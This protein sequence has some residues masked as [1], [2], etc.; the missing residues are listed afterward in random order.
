[1]KKLIKFSCIGSTDSTS[2]SRKLE[3]L[4]AV[5]ETVQ[6]SVSSVSSTNMAAL[7]D[8]VSLYQS[9]KE[10]WKK[11]PCNLKKCGEILNQLKVNS[12]YFTHIFIL[13][14]TLYIK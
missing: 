5:E 2:R 9:L 6:A 10:E 7:K 12:Y 14:I 8:V 13:L 11:S 3:A 1:M 4:E